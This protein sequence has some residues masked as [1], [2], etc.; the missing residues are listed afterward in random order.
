MLQQ[1]DELGM[2][3]LHKLCLNSN[4]KP[5]MFKL[6]ANVYPQAATIQVQ[7]V[8]NVEYDDYDRVTVVDDRREMVTP[9]KLLLKV[10]RISYHDEDFNEE[11][12]MTLS[13]V[14]Q[15]DMEFNDVLT[16]MYIQQSLS[17]NVDQNEGTKLY[18]FMQAA[19][20]DGRNSFETVYQLALL[21]TRLIYEFVNETLS[22]NNFQDVLK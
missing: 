20:I 11:G 8:T 3:P 16:I 2:T 18:P 21:E 5:E 13:T 12:R 7:M 10:K 15:K 19:T 1:T 6:L 9:I 17:E 14:L 22:K 4:A